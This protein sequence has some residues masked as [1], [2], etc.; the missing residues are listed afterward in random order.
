MEKKCVICGSTDI[1]ELKNISNRKL[2]GCN[3]CFHIYAEGK[4]YRIDYNVLKMGE[5]P[6]RKRI[7][8]LI[9][10]ISKFDIEKK[11]VID[12]GCGDGSL[13]SELNNKFLFNTTSGVEISNRSQEAKKNLDNIY[14]IDFNDFIKI[15]NKYDIILSFHFIEHLENLSDLVGINEILNDDGLLFLE[16]PHRSGS[17]LLSYDLNPSHIHQFSIQSLIRLSEMID[18]EVIYIQ[19]MKYHS[20][21]YNDSIF[22]CTRKKKGIRPIIYS[23]KVIKIAPNE[24]IIIWGCSSPT[25]NETL[26][27]IPKES[28]KLIVDSNK[29]LHGDKIESFTISDPDNI[30]NYSNLTLIINSFTSTEQIKKIINDRY[31]D[32]ISRVLTISDILKQEIND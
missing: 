5:N 21:R 28:V 27:L 14:N 9:D 1:I 6:E 23:K 15:G 2:M 8:D 13:L 3:N 22:V 32:C 24:K 7:D 11:D 20:L 10:I 19:S 12:L 16:V 26:E 18:H 25:I 29:I 31:S 17:T 30:K 4:E